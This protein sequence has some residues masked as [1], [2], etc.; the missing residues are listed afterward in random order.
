M[1][2]GVISLC[3]SGITG[4]VVIDYKCDRIMDYKIW[5]LPENGD[6]YQEHMLVPMTQ[7]YTNV[8]KCTPWL[9]QMLVA[10]ATCILIIQITELRYG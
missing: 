6:T 1:L 7:A 3:D 10:Y 9:V 2:V 4:K 5:Y 8:T